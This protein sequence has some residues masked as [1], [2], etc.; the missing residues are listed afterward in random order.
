MGLPARLKMVL[1]GPLK[2]ET[3]PLTVWAVSPPSGA[4]EMQLTPPGGLE[5]F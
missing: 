4:Q 5:M 2:A 3:G 1:Q